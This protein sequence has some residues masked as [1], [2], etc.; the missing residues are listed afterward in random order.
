MRR[1]PLQAVTMLL[2]IALV[3]GCSDD[4]K[5]Q[6]EFRGKWELQVRSYPDGREVL[7]PNVNGLAEWFPMDKTRAHATF[8]F[9]SEVDQIQLTG[10]VYD[11]GGQTFTRTEYLN[12]GGGYGLTYQPA[13]ETPEEESRGTRTQDGTVY[14]LVQ[15]GGEIFAFQADTLTVTYGDGTVNTWLRTADQKGVLAK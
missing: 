15:S 10:A 4:V 3:V 5:H 8:S 13:Y 7:A 6:A 14:K 9:S 2:L 11:L 12:I 1:T